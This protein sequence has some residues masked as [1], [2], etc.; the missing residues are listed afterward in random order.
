MKFVRI[1]TVAKQLSPQNNE[2]L[3]RFNDVWGDNC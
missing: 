2:Y 1:T 3:D